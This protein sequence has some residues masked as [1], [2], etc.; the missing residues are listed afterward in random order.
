MVLGNGILKWRLISLQS[1]R[2]FILQILLE[3]LV[4]YQKLVI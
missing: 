3:L 2:V 1:V 4:F